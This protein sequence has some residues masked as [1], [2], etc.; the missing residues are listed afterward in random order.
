M[1]QTCQENRY[2]NLTYSEFCYNMF[3]GNSMIINMYVS[4]YVCVCT[5]CIYVHMY[6][7]MCV[8]MYVCVYVC[9]YAITWKRNREIYS[10]HN[11]IFSKKACEI[12][13]ARVHSLA[14]SCFYHLK[15]TPNWWSIHFLPLYP[16][17]WWRAVGQGSLSQLPWGGGGIHSGR[18]A[19]LMFRQTSVY[20]YVPI[21]GPFRVSHLKDACLYHD[22]T[23]GE[24]TNSPSWRAPSPQDTNMRS[25]HGIFFLQLNK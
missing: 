5:V 24:H 12:T 17:K 11:S 16:F 15:R 6:V 2:S 14:L 25:I 21:K 22:E 23:W 8:C 19:Y 3:Y 18:V 4:I 13:T 10:F 1:R 20:I 9:M 7:C